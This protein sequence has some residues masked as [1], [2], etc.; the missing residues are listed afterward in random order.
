[1]LTNVTVTGNTTTI[2]QGGGISNT[3]VATLTDSRVVNNVAAA[4]TG[5]GIYSFQGST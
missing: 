4:S 2:Y 3:G 1:M 5:G